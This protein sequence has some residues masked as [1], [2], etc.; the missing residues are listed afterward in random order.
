LSA[1]D[2]K[3]VLIRRI[4]LAALICVGVG[5]GIV[6]S[7]VASEARRQN[8][9]IANTIADVLK[10]QLVRIDSALDLPQRY[11]D[12]TAVL[13]YTL[14]PGQ[15]VNLT[16]PNEASHSRCIG[17]DAS[18][19]GAP[20]WFERF[21]NNMLLRNVDASLRIV[22]RTD[23]RGKLEVTANRASIA[24]QAWVSTSD[25]LR[26]SLAL[27]IIMC[28]LV[29]VAVDRA[30]RPTG[31]ILEGLSTLA[32]GDLT[33][34][35]P[36][37][38]LREL[39]LISNGLNTLSE[40]LQVATVERTELAR[41]LIDAQEQERRHIARDLHD[42]V[43]Q[44]LTAMSGFA[45]S[46][47]SSFDDGAPI[48]RREVEDLVRTSGAAMRSLRETLTY[49]RPQEIDDLGLRASLEGLTAQYNELSRGK[50]HFQLSIEGQVDLF[51]AETA[52]HIYRIVQ[53]GLNNAARHANASTVSVRLVNKGAVTMTDGSS[54]DSVELTIGDDG[55]GWSGNPTRAASGNLGLLG[56][57]ERVSALGGRL[58]FGTSLQGGALLNA[59]FAVPT[60]G[61]TR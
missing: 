8:L 30:L 46:I 47:Q 12:W 22:N 38:R 49:L 51:D 58:S 4:L 32:R 1:F 9:Q 16:V 14:E 37:Y 56:M 50:T 59:Q 57:S 13:N 27:I 31:E 5:V 21:Y 34:R 36:R 11:P 3:W 55:A 61:V 35:L 54:Q 2:L 25:M 41:R 52:A 19:P 40:R 7:N 26:L 23:Y 42:D 33:K 60:G 24:R 45:A 29:Y 28:I 17:T 39:D 53:E 20:R 6:L 44:K 48:D 10:L 43:A 18:I 15:C